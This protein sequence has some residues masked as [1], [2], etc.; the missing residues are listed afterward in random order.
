MEAVSNNGQTSWY[1]VQ[2]KP[3]EG[4]RA[5]E[6][7]A[8][9]QIHC[10][11]PTHRVR[12]RRAGQLHWQVESLFPHYL[13]VRLNADQSVAKVNSTRGVARLVNSLGRPLVVSDA[14]VASVIKQCQ[15]LNNEAPEPE[16][17]AGT[18]VTITEGCFK[19]LQAI[20]QMTRGEDRVVLLLQLL[21]KEQRLEL[22]IKAV[23]FA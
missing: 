2:C 13:F 9:Q 7:L 21:S 1:L 11:H 19:H 12:R 5:A 8:N 17:K 15:V 18:V 10:F 14:I 22:P 6:H 3:K 23:Q 4:F 16:L 20:V